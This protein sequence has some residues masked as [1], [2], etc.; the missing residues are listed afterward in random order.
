MPGDRPQEWTVATLHEFMLK[1][2]EEQDKRY[3]Q[4]FEAQEKAVAAALASAREAVLKAE[5]ANDK[6][7]DSTN[8]W[9]RTVSDMLA[10]IQ[11]KGTGLNQGWGYLVAAV[12]LVGSIIVI[13]VSLRK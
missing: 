9:R 4:R 12:A 8:E 7:F 5:Q 10:A 1:L 6:R 2:H 3:E 11:G 13:F